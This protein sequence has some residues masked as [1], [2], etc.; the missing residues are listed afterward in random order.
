M[1]EQPRTTVAPGSAEI[2]LVWRLLP[3]VLEAG[4]LEMRY[5]REGVAVQEKAD[6]SPVTLADQEAEEVLLAALAREAPGIPV[7]AEESVAAGRIPTVGSR[8]FLVDPLDGTK[9]FINKRDEF[10]VNVA[11]VEDGVPVLGIV[12]VPALADLYV[13]LGRTS[14]A[15]ARLAPDARPASLDAC[16][17]QRISV[18]SP[19]MNGLVAVASRSHMTPETEAFLSGYRIAQRRD[20]GSSL[21]FCAVA[22][23][24]AD[25]YPRLAPTME[26]DTA[27]G[28]A[29]LRAAGGCVTA[30][31]GSPFR[32]GKA[33]AGF[34]NGHFVAWGGA[35]PFPRG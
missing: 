32:Y 28:D 29:V 25:I 16:G 13:T 18:R 15:R 1:S 21:K 17:L 3:S 8:F 22:R 7:V 5:Y 34:R 4:A 14:A 6:A 33:D 9:E 23:G 19:D 27:A 30:P 2:D 35:A 20:S 11:L 24:E 26:W 12:Y 10:T 31:D